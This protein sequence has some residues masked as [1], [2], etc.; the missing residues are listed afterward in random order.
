M[1][2]FSIPGVGGIIERRICG[3]DQILIQDRFKEDAPLERGLIEIPA[4]KVRQYENIFDCLR[5]EI[6]E[7]TGL[8]IVEIEGE[9][10]SEMTVLNGY[11]VINYT[12]FNSS[13]NTEGYYPIMVQT[14]ICRTEG[15]LLV[16]SDETRNLR[17]I[18]IEE[19]RLLLEGNE[20][21]FYPMHLVTLKKY[22]MKK[23]EVDHH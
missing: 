11:R 10:E 18:S 14:F 8:E 6:K 2:R 1:E 20:S 22:L 15:E 23:V 12:P 21:A 13:Q 9:Q 16:T 17:W 5:R 3:V 7:E 19:L 4:G